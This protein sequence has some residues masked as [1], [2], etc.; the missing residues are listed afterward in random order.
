MRSLL[1]SLACM[2]SLC[3]GCVVPASMEMSSVGGIGDR[4]TEHAV[5]YSKS[6]Y[7]DPLVQDLQ[8]V[9]AKHFGGTPAK[10]PAAEV[11]PANWPAQPV[12][13]TVTAPSDSP[14]DILWI[15]VCHLDDQGMPLGCEPPQAV[16]RSDW[17][18][19]WAQQGGSLTWP[20]GNPK[21]KFTTHKVDRYAITD[22][23][24]LPVVNVS[25]FPSEPMRLPL[26]ELPTYAAWSSSTPTT[27]YTTYRRV[28]PI[29]SILR[30]R[31]IFNFLAAPVRFLCRRCRGC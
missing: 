25:T 11:Q 9:V 1:I 7:V 4:I 5:D 31:P 27:N 18:R 28:G 26:L 13:P 16:K 22:G 21:I 15:V 29:R 8:P 30:H 19:F 23:P 24:R 14:N 6:R 17:P 20:N 10:W 12:L 3:S 2:A